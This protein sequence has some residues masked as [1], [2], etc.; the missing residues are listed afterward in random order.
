MIAKTLPYSLG[1]LGST[2][3]TAL[4][5]IINDILLKALKKESHYPH[6]MIDIVHLKSTLYVESYCIKKL[7]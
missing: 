7:Q 5:K 2:N 4:T 6:E 1:I 3:K